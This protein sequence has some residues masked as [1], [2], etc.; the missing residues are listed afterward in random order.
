MNRD[1]RL[2]A[3]DL[4]GTLLN[5]RKELTPRTLRAIKRA[6]EAGIE[7]VPATG[8]FY[9]GCPEELRKLHFIRY[10]VV[11]NGACVYDVKNDSFIH[12][13]DIPAADAVRIFDIVKNFPAEYECYAEGWG[14]APKDLAARID[15]F[16]ESDFA[17]R[18]VKTL[19]TTV[20]DL[21]A[22]VTEHFDGVHKIQMFTDDKS[23][24]AAAACAVHE[25]YPDYL[26]THA[27][28]CNLE[29]NSPKAG[30]GNAL[31][32]LASHLGLSMDQVM[33]FGDGNNDISM[34]KAAG[35]GV[36]MAN[37]M[38]EVKAVADRVT[39]SCDEEGVAAAIEELL[40]M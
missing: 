40:G 8:R 20:S 15:E 30:K 18:I 21:S 5:S 9:R 14:Y 28:D 2:I 36:A 22:Y 4:D 11:I 24:L 37:A 3:T 17:R 12:R 7:F 13:T 39:L 33:V 38:P 27:L 23:V 34:L 10:A 1:I 25:V 26:I 29:I 6:A 35:C 32:A 16:T 31:K 19:R